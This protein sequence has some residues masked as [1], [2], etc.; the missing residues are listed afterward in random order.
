MTM[1]PNPPT[2]DSPTT[3]ELPSADASPHRASTGDTGKMIDAASPGCVLPL[4][5]VGGLF[6]CA[7]PVL[8]AL[9]GGL[10]LIDNKSQ[11]ISWMILVSLCLVVGVLIG[12]A[13]AAIIWTVGRR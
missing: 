1:K 5:I 12:L 8:L 3:P 13:V 10:V 2:S 11:T 4:V 9:Y 7:L 6:G